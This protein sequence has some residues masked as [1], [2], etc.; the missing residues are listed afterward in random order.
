LKIT[1]GKNLMIAN[2]DLGQHWLNDRASLEMIIDLADLSLNDTVLEIG[3]GQG[4]LTELLVKK[5]ARVVAVEV[6][7]SLIIDLKKRFINEPHLEI[8]SQDIRHYDLTQL[9]ADYKCVANIPYYLTSYLIRLLSQSL[10]P[11]SSAVLLVQREVAERLTAQ[12]GQMSVLAIMAQVYWQVELGPIIRAEL[13]SPAPKV[14]SRIIK[15]VRR[16]H[17]LMPLGLEKEFMWLVKI[18]FSQK[19]KTLLNS[20]SAGLRIDKELAR[21]YLSSIGLDAAIRA[22]ALDIVSW[23]ELSQLIFGNE[24]NK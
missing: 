10:N 13:F 18:G 12:P 20:L 11:A 2:K 8:V 7:S 1:F 4:S 16:P 21:S 9:P 3:P 24:H 15:L 19:R 17:T 23:Q 5:A 22:Q 14:D 6:D